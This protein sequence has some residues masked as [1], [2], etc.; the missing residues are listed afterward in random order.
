M[1]VESE[2]RDA[3][4]QVASASWAE[5]QSPRQHCSSDA[6]SLPLYKH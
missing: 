5:L 4:L 3:G 6:G 1:E 2:M